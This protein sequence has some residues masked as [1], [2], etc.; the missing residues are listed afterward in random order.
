MTF[1]L[2]A[3]GDVERLGYTGRVFATLGHLAFGRR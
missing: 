3:E 2:V 1:P